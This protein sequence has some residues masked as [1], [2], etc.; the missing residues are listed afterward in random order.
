MKTPQMY[1][2]EINRVIQSFM[3]EVENCESAPRSR[4]GR[5]RVAWQ[6]ASPDYLESLPMLRLSPDCASYGGGA[7][8]KDRA[9]RQSLPTD[10]GT[11]IRRV[12]ETK[13]V[14]RGR[15]RPL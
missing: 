8:A 5:S 9:S 4:V 10:Q 13:R 11:L 14:L 6:Q 7:T 1:R 2:S 12:G 15:R 3:D